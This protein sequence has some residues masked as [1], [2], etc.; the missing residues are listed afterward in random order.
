MK[1]MEKHGPAPEEKSTAEKRER[2]G[3][4]AWFWEM[5]EH[6]DRFDLNI[7]SAVKNHLFPVVAGRWNALRR[8]I[9]QQHQ[10]RQEAARRWLSSGGAEA[11][12]HSSLWH[13]WMQNLENWAWF[14]GEHPHW[15]DVDLQ[16]WVR[17]YV[18][19][20]VR[21]ER[22]HLRSLTHD[23]RQRKFPETEHRIGQFF[24]FVWGNL[25]R[26]GGAF[27]D[28]A[29]KRR[30]TVGAAQ[31]RWR[32]AFERL[33]VHPAAFLGGAM[34]IAAVALLLSLYTLGTT[35]RYDGVDLGTVSGRRVV[36]DAVTSIEEITRKTLHDKDYAVD[37]DK[38]EMHT[39]IVKRSRLETPA[40]LQDNLSDQIGKVDYGYALYVNDE[41]I[42]ATTF[43]G[44]LEELL[45]QMKAGYYTENTVECRFSE[46]V[47]IREGY[48]DS[49]YMMNLGYIAKKLNDTKANEVTYRVKAGDAWSQIA[50]D[51]NMT[52]KELLQ[53]N[54]GYD[55]GV[56]H[57]GD[58]LTI[59]N[60][61]PYLTVVNVERQSYVQNVPYRIKYKNDPSMYEGDF[62]VL[63]EGSYGKADVT[64]NVTYVNG[65][66]I[67]RETVASVTLRQPQ[68]EVQARGTKHRP[69]WH[70]TGNFR[71]PCN[72][73]ITSHFGYRDTGIAG[74]S[75][76]HEGI[77]IAN[78]TG[79][80]VYAS[81]GGTVTHAGWF[82]G[83][84][85]TVKIDHGNGFV[86]YYAHCNDVLVS[87]GD[88]VYKGE[89]V[90]IMGSTG[91][92]SG[93]HCHFG[94]LKNNT[95]VN[96]VDYLS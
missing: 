43:P 83:M 81:D 93:P 60:A 14:H 2:H 94:L 4:R 35:A 34:C 16:S 18:I 61:V 65:E 33:K 58:E 32:M 84:G 22:D 8:H 62:K 25:P 66:E 17:H 31:G 11:G 57:V 36:T 59:T 39:S 48:V 49:K 47:D 15:Y 3:L 19:D 87:A 42:A 71:W 50:A 75:S 64:A 23:K 95:W 88:H 56:L 73:V 55:P 7:Q 51:N 37:L 78:Y 67:D 91:I 90:A 29:L 44:A 10:V 20:P 85:Y 77:D 21:R 5:Q 53:L 72:G 24:L 6:P 41:L 9:A 96:P 74:A 1:Q 92:S 63:R 38:L 82:G 86:S 79:C 89:Q 52:I 45:E 30:K 13:R 76:Y 27:H 80:P 12:E 69:T 54:P 26:C 70:P 46:N 28:R 68:A 40:T